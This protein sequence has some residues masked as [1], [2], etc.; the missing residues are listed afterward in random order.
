M[1]DSY[2]SVIF[3]SVQILIQANRS[4]EAHYQYCNTC[5]LRLGS[6]RLRGVHCLFLLIWCEECLSD[7]FSGLAVLLETELLS[8]KTRDVLLPKKNIFTNICTSI[9]KDIKISMRSIQ[10]TIQRDQI[11]KLKKLILR[12]KGAKKYKI[13]QLQGIT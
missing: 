13:N 3:R 4:S 12:A 9:C 10:F 1:T 5:L 7:S 11:L 2:E 8:T 6:V